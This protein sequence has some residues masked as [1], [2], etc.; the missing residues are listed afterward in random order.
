MGTHQY[1]TRRP[2]AAG[3]RLGLRSGSWGSGRCASCTA[4]PSPKRALRRMRG[5][6]QPKGV[7]SDEG[8]G[9]VRA[10]QRVSVGCRQVLRRS[11]MGRQMALDVR[12]KSMWGREVRRGSNRTV[13][14]SVLMATPHSSLVFLPDC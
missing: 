1:A 6:C 10:A 9:A 7:A 8:G 2:S 5:R 4:V 14:V 11:Q 12:P 3:V 13:R